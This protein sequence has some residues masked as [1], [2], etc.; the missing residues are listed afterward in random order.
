[1]PKLSY[2]GAKSD[3][4]VA[5][6]RFFVPRRVPVIALDLPLFRTAGVRVRVQQEYLL[7]PEVS[8]NK[9]RKLKYNLLA[10]A[11]EAHDSLVTMGGAYSNHL[12]A[13]AAAGHRFGW[14]TLGYVRGEPVEPL[15]APLRYC[16]N[17]GMRLRYCARGEFRRLRSDAELQRALARAGGAR[18]YFLPEG[19]TNDLAVRGCAEMWTQWAGKTPPDVVAVCAGTGGTAAGLISGA[20]TGTRIEVYP[21]LKGD[22][23]R[24]E[25]TRYLPENGAT[26]WLLLGD[27]HCGGY[28]KNPPALRAFLRAFRAQTDLPVEPVY[29]GKLFYGLF[30]RIGRGRYPRGTEI[31][32]I[33]TGPNGASA[34]GAQRTSTR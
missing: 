27:Y 8:G 13:V 25:I 23:L 16:R 7:H 2:G 5:V 20:P 10:A 18:P 34:S 21:A 6:A 15:N 24:E 11:D 12:V 14:P 30:D 33:H 28:A 22:F 19:G 3:R 31:L 9:W 26:E 1:M 17:H 29:T 32:V 4:R